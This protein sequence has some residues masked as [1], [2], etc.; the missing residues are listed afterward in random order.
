[1]ILFPNCKINIGLQILGKRPDGFHD[2]ETLF[3][4]VPLQDALEIVSHPSEETQVTVTGMNIDV[5]KEDNICYKAWSV[6]RKDFPAI[7]PVKIHLHKR[8][9]AGAGLGGGSA[10]GAFT[11]LLL[12]KKYGLKLNET[13][14][15]QYALQLGSDC[16]FFI[17][18]RP[19]FATGRGE[20]LQDLSL[21]LSGYEIMVV[22]PGIH[23]NTAEAFRGIIPSSE[24]PS[25]KELVTR[26]IAEWKGQV[27]NDFEVSVFRD[28][29][30]IEAIREQLY[31]SGAV[32]AS[33]TGTGS[34][35]YGFYKKGD[36]PKL[37]F[38]DHY[39]IKLVKA[40]EALI[41]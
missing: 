39:F 28:Y 32:Y 13:Q 14:L 35:V 9:P 30:E 4:P 36:T 21:D 18:N 1:M 20:E 17:R 5:R 26:P 11:L 29:P 24:R 16:P 8:I 12:N 34:T 10:D 25:L 41:G 33:M 37:S 7:P 40:A 23:I 6:L 27:Q 3:Y 15:F 19:S 31:N 22:N 38:P 2:L